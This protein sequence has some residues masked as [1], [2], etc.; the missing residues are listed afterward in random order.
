MKN[1]PSVLATDRVIHWKQEKQIEK[2]ISDQNQDNFS[3]FQSSLFF[4][5]FFYS[6]SLQRISFSVEISLCFGF[7]IGMF[8]KTGVL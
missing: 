3:E 6:S 8:L 7:Q 2:Q 1:F 4:A 5:P